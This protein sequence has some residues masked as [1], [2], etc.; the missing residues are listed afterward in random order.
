MLKGAAVVVGVYKW[1]ERDFCVDAS[2]GLVLCVADI[3]S[4]ANVLVGRRVVVFDHMP[5]VWIK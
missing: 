3:V 4:V 1:T 5:T 2:D